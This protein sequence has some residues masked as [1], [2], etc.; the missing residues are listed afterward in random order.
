[1]SPQ[2]GGA[3]RVLVVDDEGVSRLFLRA[4]LKADG[5]TVDEACDARGAL[6]RLADR[7][8]DVVLL[9]LALGEG[10]GGLDVLLHLR[11]LPV[12]DSTAVIVVSGTKRDDHSLARGL[13]SGADDYLVKPV[14]PI[15][16]RAR[17][18]RARQQVARLRSRDQDLRTLGTQIERGKSAIRDAA[19]AQRAGDPA[20]PLVRPG[21][22]ASGAILAS[23]TV[24]GDL[25]DVVDGPDGAQTAF[26]IDVAGHGLGAGMLGAE[27][28]GVLRASIQGAASLASALGTAERFLATCR[29]PR[30]AAVAS[31][32]AVRFDATG[33]EVINA[34]LPPIAI[35]RSDGTLLLASDRP[36]IGL[37]PMASRPGT[38]LA[39]P[40]GGVV[41]LASDG[42]LHDGLDAEAMH[43]LLARTS[44]ASL[45]TWLAR[46]EPMQLEQLLREHLGLGPTCAPSD[47][48]AL[49][50]LARPDALRDA[51]Q[52]RELDGATRL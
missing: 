28:R 43:E 31:I 50:V 47:D 26:L 11:R 52:P 39:L 1:M 7:H 9:D 24:S 35:V 34:G 20:L 21:L 32:G 8:Y 16:L 38:R 37:R 51:L 44:M 40:P 36:P 17:V 46:A 13:A 27:L 30:L 5:H 6:A 12:N 23:E 15:E 2:Q 14:D 49:L 25:I 41:V 19:R 10:A 48:A 18:I 45:R 22:L 4:A 3:G 42:A 33:I 29:R